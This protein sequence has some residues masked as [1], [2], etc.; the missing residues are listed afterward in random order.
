MIR[1]II[2]LFVAL[3]VIVPISWLMLDRRVPVTINVLHVDPIAKPGALLKVSWELSIHRR[4]CDGEVVRSI[5]DAAGVIHSYDVVSAPSY[6]GETE[7]AIFSREIMLPTSIAIGPARLIV[8]RIYWCNTIQKYWW[9]IS[10]PR[11]EVHF[12]VQ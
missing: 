11:R 5:V 8:G 6:R 2:G 1:H 3:F 12:I 4:H 9:P 10:T 7:R